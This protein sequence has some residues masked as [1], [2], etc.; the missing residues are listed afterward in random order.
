MIRRLVVA[1]VLVLVIPQ[2][3]WAQG[4]KPGTKKPAAFRMDDF[5]KAQ[6]VIL[7]S[8][9]TAGQDT[10]AKQVAAPAASKSSGST[11]DAP[12][13]AKVLGLAIDNDLVGVTDGALTLSVTP[14]AFKSLAHPEILNDGDLYSSPA[15]SFLRRIGG[16]FTIG[17]KGEKFDRDGDGKADDP[18]APDDLTDIVTSELRVRFFGVRDRND[19]RTI[20][21]Y[22]K[23]KRDGQRRLDQVMIGMVADINAMRGADWFKPIEAMRRPCEPQS[24]D[25]CYF[26]DSKEAIAAILEAQHDLGNLTAYEEHL[27]EAVK[28]HEGSIKSIDRS[29]EWSIVGGF[30]RQG[31]DFGPNRRHVGLRGLFPVGVSDHTFNLDWTQAESRTSGKPDATSIK[32]AYQIART[33]QTNGVTCSYSAAWERY[34]HVPDAK[35]DSV[36]NT[37]VKF[38]IPITDSVS[39]PLSVTWA[40]HRDLLTKQSVLKGHV[41]LAWDFSGL[42]KKKDKK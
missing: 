23:F 41:G 27:A 6:L 20:E 16:S 14:F 1:A 35:H 28:A 25:L 5:L 33:F 15:N 31:V 9:E 19:T 22:L 11:V 17:G 2:L 8:G 40:N 7:S 42:T 12:S 21:R 10:D 3:G 13:F 29:A 34:Q 26:D 37:G 36:V 18:K 38:E 39:L 32:A 24:A 4:A 30:T